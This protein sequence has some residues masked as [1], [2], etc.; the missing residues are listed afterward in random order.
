MAKDDYVHR[1]V[2]QKP[3]ALRRSG[4]IKPPHDHLDPKNDHDRRALNTLD[5]LAKEAKG[6]PKPAR[7]CVRCKQPLDR[8]SPQARLCIS[9]QSETRL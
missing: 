2:P 4:G 1:Q 6:K 9:C 8:T 5:K 7:L 3:R